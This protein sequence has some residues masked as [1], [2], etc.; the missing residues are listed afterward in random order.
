M[1]PAKME[2]TKNEFGNVVAG[3]IVFKWE[4]RVGSG[5]R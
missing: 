4:I 1:E 5:P 3:S 2:P